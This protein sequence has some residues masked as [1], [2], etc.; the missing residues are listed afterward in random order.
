AGALLAKLY[1]RPRQEYRTFTER[2]GRVRDIGVVTTV[3]SRMLLVSVALLA[4][5]ATAIVYGLGGV[6]VVDGSFALGTLIALTV[7]VTR[8]FGPVNQLSTLQA[9][10]MTALVSFDRL[11]EVLDLK[12]LI[13]EKPG[14]VALNGAGRAPE[15]EFTDVSFRYP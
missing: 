11:F 12:P 14:A 9:S 6:L 7:L 15:I 2:A 1:G 4:S 10:V 8:L 3:Y 5:L 13:A